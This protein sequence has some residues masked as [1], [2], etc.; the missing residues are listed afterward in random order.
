MT[1]IELVESDEDGRCDREHPEDARVSTGAQAIEELYGEPQHEADRQP[2]ERK[3][4]LYGEPQHEERAE[5]RWGEPFPWLLDD[6]D[7]E[8]DTRSRTVP[9]RR[10]DRDRQ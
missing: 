7:E 2:D 3:E 8:R 6:A 1:P 9:L 5:C 4:A 10:L